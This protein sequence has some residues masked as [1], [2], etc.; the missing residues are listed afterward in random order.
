VSK[1][2]LNIYLKQTEMSLFFLN[3]KQEGRTSPVW[4]LVPVAAGEVV[5]RECRRV[6][7]VQILSIHICKWKNK[8]F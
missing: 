4:G 6:N 2:P 5:G 3:G 1:K 7:M 8:I